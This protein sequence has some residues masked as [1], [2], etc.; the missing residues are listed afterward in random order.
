MS[1]IIKRALQYPTSDAVKRLNPQFFNNSHAEVVK[2][3]GPAI[4]NPKRNTGHSRNDLSGKFLS[5]WEL[6]NGPKLEQE[7]RFHPE[8]KFR[9]DFC[10]LSTRTCI[11]IEGGIFSK[12][13]GHSSVTGILRDIDK[14]N[15]LT[16]LGFRLFRFHGKEGVAGSIDVANL[17]RLIRFLERPSLNRA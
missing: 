6:L 17:T 5:I 11:E 15:E 1:K 12:H 16:F 7:F 14:Y 8:R 10:H 9:C 2:P 4:S 13:G 3:S